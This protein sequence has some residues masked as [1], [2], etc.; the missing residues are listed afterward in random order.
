MS[1]Q[2]NQW[3][4]SSAFSGAN[5]AFMEALYEQFLSDPNSVS[6]AWQLEFQQINQQDG[7]EVPHQPIRQYFKQLAQQNKKVASTTCMSPLAATKQTSVL[8]LINSYRVRGHQNAKIDPLDLNPPP[9]VADL[10]PTFHGL[11]DADM[12]Q[13]FHSGSLYTDQKMTLSE[14]LTF[15]KQVYTGTVG[16]EYMHITSTEQKRWIQKRLEGYLVRPEMDSKDKLWLLKQLTAAEGLETYLHH[17]YVGQKRFSLEGCD[18]LIVLLDEIIQRTTRK[19]A[20]ELVISMAHRGRLNV[21][22]NIVGKPPNQLFDEFEGTSAPKE[23][24]TTGD[25]K[26]HMGFSS[27][28]A[29]DNEIVHVVLGFNPSHLEIAA[30][31]IQGSARARQQRRGDKTGN[32]V[33]PIIIHGDAAVAG[34]GVVMESLN[35]S[36]TRGFT[37]GGSLHIVINN[38]IGFTTSNPIDTRSSAYCTDIAKMVEAP[39]FHVNADDPEAVL[40]VTRLAVDYRNTFNHDVFIDLIGYRRHGHNEADEP[41]VTQPLMYKKIRNHPTARQIYAEKLLAEGE[42]QPDE[43]KNMVAEYRAAL[44]DD[45]V[46]SRPIVCNI[47]NPFTVDWTP[48]LN[49]DWQVQVKTAISCDKIKKLANLLLKFPPELVVHNRIEKIMAD[50]AQMAMGNKRVD[51]GFAENLAYASLVEAGHP[52]RLSGEDVG[53]GTFF[54][55]HAVLTDQNTGEHYVPLQHIRENQGHF[56]VINSLLSEEA[57]LAFEYGYSITEPYGLT[58]WEAQ[59]GDFANGA[60]VVIDQFITSGQAKWGLLCGLTL[61][62][63][64]GYEGMGPEHSSARVERYLQLCAEHNIQVCIPTTPAQIFHLLRRQMLR[65]LRK[66]LIV[67]SPKSL[68]RHPQATS[69]MEELSSGEF[70]TVIA[71]TAALDNQKIKQIIMCSGKIYYQ[72]RETRDARGIDDIAI[73]R[74]EQLYPFPRD[75]FNKVIDLY[76]NAK[77]LVWCQEEPQNQ[78]A[79]DQIKH[80]FHKQIMAGKALYYTGRGGAAAPAEGYGKLYKENQQ[81]CIDDALSGNFNPQMNRR[82][83]S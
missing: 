22:T 15:L 50:R 69:S 6:P 60:Q 12:N 36:D 45:W 8:R 42:I 75:C 76:P 1:T 70:Q 80:R 3:Q 34:Q 77:I 73:I 30:P 10:N 32:E 13:V 19:G 49:D 52:V 54:H 16:S 29:V 51:W 35:M 7:A 63:P 79:W 44:E 9:A 28:I 55:R 48:F 46:S 81:K 82:I 67:F 74:I 56:V 38:Q 71:E 78:G 39:I 37:T 64:H 57:V 17:K 72:L 53:R 5:A 65:P 58:I 25:V 27:D 18:S 68:L 83:S 66:P 41:A 62:L 23:L 14:I 21:L 47:S 26:Y 24:M 31:V 4:D 59:F 2:F 33:I 11:S 20:K 61:L 43:A 40:F